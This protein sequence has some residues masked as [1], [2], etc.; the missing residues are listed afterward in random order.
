M[1]KQEEFDDDDDDDDDEWN[2]RKAA[3][4]CLNLFSVCCEDNVVKL[5]FPFVKV[6]PEN[7]LILANLVCLGS[8][9]GFSKVLLDSAFWTNTY[10]LT[11]QLT[12][13]NN[14]G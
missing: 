8:F 13:K 7:C 10:Y 3:G 9:Y 11:C 1:S 6:G 12:S 2:P 14:R 5:A 4:M